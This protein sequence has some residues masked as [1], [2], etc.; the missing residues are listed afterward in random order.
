MKSYGAQTHTHNTT[1]RF[2]YPALSKQWQY[3]TLPAGE[4]FNPPPATSSL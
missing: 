3:L 2:H 1:R 4:S